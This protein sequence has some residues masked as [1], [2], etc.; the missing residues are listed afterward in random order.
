MTDNQTLRELAEAAI[1][2][3]DTL[4]C[5]VYAREFHKAASPDVVLSILDRLDGA[6][7]SINEHRNMCHDFKETNNKLDEMYNGLAADYAALKAERAALQAKN[8]VLLDALK[9][10]CSD[11]DCRDRAKAA[12]AQMEESIIQ[13]YLEKDISQMEESK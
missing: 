10:N 5:R 1:E 13:N 11:W 7:D 8:Q 2:L 6:Y 9:V 12:I 4:D 3:Q